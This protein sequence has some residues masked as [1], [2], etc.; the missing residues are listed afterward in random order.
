MLWLIGIDE[1]G[2]GPNL[3]PL[4]QAAVAVR[5]PD[6]R[7]LWEHLAAAVR[8]ADDHDD[9]RVLIDDSKRV[10][11][12]P[13][14]L[15]R[16]ELGVASALTTHWG[17][18]LRQL[19]GGVA[20]GPSLDDL[21]GEPWFGPDEP[22][23]AAAGADQ[24]AAVA[25]RLTA[26][27]RACGLEFRAARCMVTPAPRFNALLD[28]WRSKA[29]VLGHGL[30]ALLKETASLECAG[31]PVTFVIDKHGG[32][33]FYAAMIH[34]A[35]SDGW[36]RAVRESAEASEYCVDGL[37][38]DL[39]LLFRPKADGNS[40]PVAL[41]SMLAKYLREVFMLQFNRYWLTH[42][43]GLKPTAGYPGDAARFYE[44]IRPAMERLGISE[45]A[46]WRRK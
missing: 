21:A 35:F 34:E 10:N 44:G 45:S 18:R 14:G 1:A 41:A 6:E 29:T 28:R 9:G 25:E 3:G 31:E 26:A 33:N 13:H 36:V 42:A 39:R 46:V 22:L 17:E 19:L 24:I 12:G 15:A 5:V 32:R 43:P 27:V 30:I 37:G 11:E 4:V 40:L 8:K 16:L 38:R 20:C 7:C 2:Y 23:P